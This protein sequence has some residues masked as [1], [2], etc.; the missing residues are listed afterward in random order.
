MSESVTVNL[1]L[2]SGNYTAY[3]EIGGKVYWRSTDEIPKWEDHR[4][5]I[6]PLPS[7][8]KESKF[9]TLV[10]SK[11]YTE[12]DELLDEIEKKEK[13]DQELREANY[14]YD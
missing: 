9:R 1:T 10:L 4:E 13:A 8:I 3:I 2:N 12:A 6:T 11:L 5:D 7:N 14:F